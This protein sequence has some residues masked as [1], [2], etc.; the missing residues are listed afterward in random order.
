MKFLKSVSFIYY[1]ICGVDKL[2]LREILRVC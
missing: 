1:Q 2:I